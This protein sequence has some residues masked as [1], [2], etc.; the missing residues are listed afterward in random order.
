MRN[1]LK[2]AYA[3]AVLFLIRPA[4]EERDSAI[5]AQHLAEWKKFADN[6]KALRK[7]VDAKANDARFSALACDRADV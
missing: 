2:A 1:Q 7:A 4:L 6:N 5:E 3:R